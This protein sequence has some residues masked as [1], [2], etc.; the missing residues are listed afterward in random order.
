MSPLSSICR[1]DSYLLLFLTVPSQVCLAR[2]AT[3]RSALRAPARITALPTPLN[4]NAEL[5]YE[6]KEG[7]SRQKYKP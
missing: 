6:K 4:Q 2:Y 1:F 3:P 5:Y 7:A